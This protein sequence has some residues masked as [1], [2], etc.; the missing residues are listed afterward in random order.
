MKVVGFTFVRNGIIFDYPFLESIRSL[1]PLCDELIV[2]VGQ[3]D[4]DTLEQIQSLQS[5]KV[6]IIKTVWD[7]SLR[8]A[9]QF[10][11]NRQ[12][13]HSIKQLAIGLF[14]FKQMKCFTKKITRPS[15][16]L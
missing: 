11:P 16:M 10:F 7:D 13:L 4:D 14:I 6:Q 2:A 8:K 9:G 5:S 1:L 15:R 3:S 12:I